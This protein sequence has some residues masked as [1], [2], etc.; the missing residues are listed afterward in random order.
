MPERATAVQAAQIGVETTPAP[1]SRPRSA[2]SSV[3]FKG[4]K[5]DTKAEM[6]QGSSSPPRSASGRTG[7]RE[8]STV[9]PAT[10]TSPISCRRS[11]WHHPIGRRR[12]QDVVVHPRRPLERRP[13]DVHARSRR[14]QHPVQPDDAQRRHRP[15]SWAKE[16]IALSGLLRASRSPTTPAHCRRRHRRRQRHHAARR[17]RL[18]LDTTSAGLGTT[19]LT[20]AI[21]AKLD[22]RGR[23]SPSF[24]ADSSEDSF[25]D[26]HR[27]GST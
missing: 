6:S 9:T 10:T 7:P 20:R 26:H 3:G 11:S 24:F 4:I 18:Y 12:R 19:R 2:S 14:R 8:R 16:N 5:V 13:Q 17:H 27:E 15:R 25:L 22:I 1:P 23:W 21:K